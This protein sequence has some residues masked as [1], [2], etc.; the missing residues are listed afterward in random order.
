MKITKLETHDRLEHFVQDQSQNIFLGAEDCLKR[1]VDSLYYQQHSPYVYLFAHPRTLD[2]DERSA[3]FLTGNYKSLG[4]T[5]SSKMIWQ[6]RL[7]KPLPQTNSYLFRATS[8]TD[9]LE[10][11]WLLPPRETW[12]QYKKDN[13]TEHELVIW[14]INQ[15]TTNREN[16][17][18]PD[19]QDL[20]DHICKDILRRYLMEIEDKKRLDSLYNTKNL[21]ETF[22]P[23]G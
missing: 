1:N 6:P 3:Y 17:E 15:F 16:L 8:N 18:K 21:P 10:V 12:D 7:S 19:P 13:L 9:Q 4:D 22:T 5:P 14:S 20:P 11:C 23:L 2:L